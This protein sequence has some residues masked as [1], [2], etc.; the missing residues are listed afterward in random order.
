MPKV[1]STPDEWIRDFPELK[2]ENN[3][4]FCRACKKFPNIPLP[5]EPIITRWGTWLQVTFYYD[6]YIKEYEEVVTEFSEDSSQSIK[7]CINILENKDLRQDLA[8]LRCNYQFVCEVIEKL[9][10]PN[11]LLVDAINLVKEFK[12]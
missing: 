8:F 5:P 10:K 6:K 11:M 4:I 9:E 7:D 3:K 1:K 12:Q 2:L